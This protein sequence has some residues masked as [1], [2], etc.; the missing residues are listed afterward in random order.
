MSLFLNALSQHGPSDAPLLQTLS[1]LSPPKRLKKKF[2]RV[3]FGQE[4][5]MLALLGPTPHQCL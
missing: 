4:F 3:R 1:A 2:T 5:I